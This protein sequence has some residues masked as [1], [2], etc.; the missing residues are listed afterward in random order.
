MPPKETYESSPLLG[1]KEYTQFSLGE[2][3]KVPEKY[4]MTRILAGG[5]GLALLLFCLWISLGDFTPTGPYV[6]VELQEGK[7]FFDYYDFFSGP[8][9]IGSAGYNTY[10]SKRRAKELGLADVIQDAKSGIEY[11][12]MQS[13]SPAGKD[14]GFRESVRLEGK[15]RFNRGLFILDVEHM[16][17]GCGVWPAFWLTDEDA[18]PGKEYCWYEIY[19]AIY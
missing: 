16:P 8:D 1:S 7:S 10:V 2:E 3:K 19:R 11:I 15:R 4:R 13:A 12:F 14:G 18:W 9:S 17:T 6:L 5:V